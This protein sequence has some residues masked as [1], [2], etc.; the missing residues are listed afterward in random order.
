MLRIG[1]DCHQNSLDSHKDGHNGFKDGQLTR[2]DAWIGRINDHGS[3]HDGYH[4]SLDDQQNYQDDRED[5]KQGKHL[6]EKM[7]VILL[8]RS[9]KMSISVVH[10]ELSHK[11]MA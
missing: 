10:I 11:K 2:K 4:H 9:L 1:H 5:S 3:R 8:G 6:F 7:W